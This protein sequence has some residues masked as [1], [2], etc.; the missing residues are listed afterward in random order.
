[1][2]YLDTQLKTVE[3]IINAGL[4][5]NGLNNIFK[6]I[7]APTYDVEML[8]SFKLWTD[9]MPLSET[10]P[11][12]T[13]ERFLHVL[14]DTIDR[15]PLSN[16]LDFALPL[17]RMIAKKLF[18]GCGENFI[19]ETNV[20]FNFG[21][22]LKLGRDVHFNQGCYFDT[23]GGIEFGDFA[24]TAEFVMIFS[25]NHS[26]SDHSSRTYEKVVIGPYAKL[27]SRC[28]IMPGVTIGEGAQVAAG[29][30]VTRDVEPY[31][32]VAGA[33]AKPIR[34]RRTDGKVGAELNHYYFLNR[35]YQKD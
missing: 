27:G 25:H 19:C 5:A 11:Y 24:M 12:T 7:G 29:A 9:Y 32:T 6:I 35:A 23:K 1:M 33:P 13:E 30:I 15:V 10:Q 4:D 22:N 31:T 28:I 14:W 16:N 26:E 20:R 3:N 2:S 34:P 17:R 18:R 21:T 8:D